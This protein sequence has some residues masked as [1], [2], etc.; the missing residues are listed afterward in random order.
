MSVAGL[1]LSDDL[2]FTSRITGIGRDL[3]LAIKPA[4][5]VDALATLAGQEAPGGVI[6]DLAFPGLDITSLIQRLADACAV[7]PRVIAYGA[8][9]DAAGLRAARQAGCD[10][11]LPRSAF[12]EQLPVQLPAWLTARASQSDS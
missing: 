4:R 12:V 1:L 5:T 6:L 10:I 11:V 3:G 2:I 9:V 7:R 8:H